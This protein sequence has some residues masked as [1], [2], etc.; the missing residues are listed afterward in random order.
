MHRDREPGKIVV[1]HQ[2]A[3]TINA[4]PTLSSILPTD[5][6]EYPRIQRLGMVTAHMD[7]PTRLNPHDALDCRISAKRVARR[8]C[9]APRLSM[10]VSPLVM[11]VVF[12]HYEGQNARVYIPGAPILLE[13]ILL[14]AGLT[15]FL[16]P[17][18]A[19]A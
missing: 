8:A 13:L 19:L 9:H 17:R 11:T 7:V 15:L 12:A 3:H 2:N 6:P 10:I 18:Q 16:L 1:A 5:R 4:T 14:V